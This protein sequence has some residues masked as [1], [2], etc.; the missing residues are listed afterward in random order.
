MVLLRK[1]QFDAAQILLAGGFCGSALKAADGDAALHAALRSGT[2]RPPAG[3][4]QALLAD[5][6]DAGPLGAPG[7]PPLPL[8]V[9]RHGCDNA[10]HQLLP[11]LLGG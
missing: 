6:A 10:V 2:S 4:L 11:S 1:S 3:L 9:A 8:A 7:A 5:G